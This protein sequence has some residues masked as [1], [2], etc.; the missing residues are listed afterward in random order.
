M[1]HFK[2]KKWPTVDLDTPINKSASEYLEVRNIIVH[3]SG[4]VS[5]LFLRR[6]NRQDLQLNSEFPLSIDYVDQ[7]SEALQQLASELDFA[8][9][10]HFN[11]PTV[12]PEDD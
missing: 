10:S 4:R 2:K 3:N 11:L 12:P 8:I 9:L 6:T 5:K 7:G 1:R